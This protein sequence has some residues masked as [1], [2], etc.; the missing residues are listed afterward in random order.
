[1]PGRN[2]TFLLFPQEV[3]FEIFKFLPMKHLLKLRRVC[4]GMNEHVTTYLKE[5]PFAIVLTLPDPD[6][7]RKHVLFF[8]DPR[9]PLHSGNRHHHTDFGPAHFFAEQLFSDDFRIIEDVTILENQSHFRHEDF[10]VLH[11]FDR[12]DGMKEFIRTYL[13]GNVTKLA[14]LIDNHE[15]WEEVDGIVS[16]FGEHLEVLFLEQTLRSGFIHPNDNPQRVFVP[17]NRLYFPDSVYRTILS[18]PQLKELYFCPKRFNRAHWNY[19]RGDAEWHFAV[20]ILRK[21]QVLHMPFLTYN[22]N[23]VQDVGNLNPSFDNIHELSAFYNYHLSQVSFP[24]VTKLIISTR[25]GRDHHR[26]HPVQVIINIYEFYKFQPN[27]FPSLVY[28]RFAAGFFFNDRSIELISGLPNLRT[29]H[30]VTFD[31]ADPDYEPPAGAIPAVTTLIVDVDDP[32]HPT[33]Q[34]FPVFPSLQTFVDRSNNLVMNED[35]INLFL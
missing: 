33:T 20:N 28:L 10:T 17:Y 26:F 8:D 29:F 15:L 13:A 35:Q 11:H 1:M 18:L 30:C 31:V 24:N 23:F 34:Y 6:R 2:R 14:L 32:Q 3:L 5:K 27:N 21:V 19:G 12:L 25:S 7:N 16:L 22:T 4:S 9:F